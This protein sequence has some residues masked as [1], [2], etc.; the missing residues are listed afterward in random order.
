MSP[1]V[2]LTRRI[3][4]AG[5][6]ILHAAGLEVE[7]GQDD[8]ER[9][10][11]R[12]AL[13]RG[14]ARADVLLSLL[15]ERIDGAVL[16]AGARLRGI[17]NMAVGYDNIDVAAAS[18]RGLPVSNTPGVLTDTTADLTWALLLAVARRVPESERYLRAGHYRVWGPE[19]FLGADV[20]PGGSGVPKTL[21]IIGFGRI[22]RAVARRA[23]G[24]DMRVLA[25]SPERAEIEALPDVTYAELD[26]L[27]RESDFVTLHAPGTPATR[28]LLGGRELGLMK[29]TAFLVNVAR[30]DL[31]D[32]AALVRALHEG[33]IAGAALDVYEREPELAAGLANCENAVLV[34]H[35][36]SASR[37][38]RALMASMAARNA[39]A[40]ARGERAPNVVNP[41]VYEAA[42]YAAHAQSRS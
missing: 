37:D 40:H 9:G 24:F 41:A 22:G 35:I 26:T 42:A 20:S 36:G 5:L 15:T 27:L 30:G 2:F 16:D 14:V 3:P 28:H 33:A 12:A 31:V 8:P 23:H 17:A 32:E 34:P 7:I 39:V 29:P 4:A 21:G 1:R 19:L 38:T 11:D 6:D 25:H 10:L 13:L 18:A